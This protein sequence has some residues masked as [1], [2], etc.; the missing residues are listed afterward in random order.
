MINDMTSSILTFKL[1]VLLLLISLEWIPQCHSWGIHL[2]RTKTN[3]SKNTN[4]DT[5][6]QRRQFFQSLIFLSFSN[7]VFYSTPAAMARNL[8]VSTGADLKKVGTVQ[9]LTPIVS[10]RYSLSK[11]E[12]HLSKSERIDIQDYDIPTIEE[13]FKR[14][15][16][17]YSDP[18]SYKQKF[19]DNNAFLVYYTKG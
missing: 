18:V 15:F 6:N 7:D 4:D 5:N 11:L 17:A 14:L 8:P 3:V 19:L 1:T 13:N 12:T 16:D 2:M 9:A 10:I